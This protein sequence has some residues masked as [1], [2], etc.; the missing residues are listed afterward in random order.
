MNSVVDVPEDRIC[1]ES[2]NNLSLAASIHKA[3][4][5]LDEKMV[6]AESCTGGEIASTLAKIPGIS[7]YLCG[8]FVTYRAASK[9]GWI[10]VDCRTIDKYTTE[11]IEVAREMAFGALR[12][13]PEA[14]WSLAVVGHFGPNSP[15]DKDGKIYI[16]VVRRSIKGKF[17]VKEELIHTLG[18]GERI[19]RQKMATEVCLTTLARIL[20]KRLGNG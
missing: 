18:V 1:R 9:H 19:P 6:F 7:K 20:L 16:C 10:G 2:R 4:S 5:E 3:I 11:S 14:S 17:K 13:T 12:K 15:E 8:S